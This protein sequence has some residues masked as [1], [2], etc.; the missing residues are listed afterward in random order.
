[1]RMLCR[2]QHIVLQCVRFGGA[3]R[4]TMSTKKVAAI[5]LPVPLDQK[6]ES[7]MR[8]L[9]W[10]AQDD[11]VHLCVQ[12]AALEVW[13]ANLLGQLNGIRAELAQVNQ[14]IN[15][16]V[17]PGVSSVSG[18]RLC[19]LLLFVHHCLSL[20]GSLWSR[21][22]WKVSP[23]RSFQTLPRRRRS[24]PR[25]WCVCTT[26][27]V[28]RYDAHATS[29]VAQKKISGVLSL[30]MGRDHRYPHRYRPM[31]LLLHRLMRQSLI[32]QRWCSSRPHQA[33][34]HHQQRRARL[35]ARLC[36]AG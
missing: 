3:F 21:P 15:G 6:D 35:V 30:S 2:V 14:A 22:Y 13:E 7:V 4:T 12:K 25:R 29:H 31:E 5:L 17:A 10:C 19:G 11:L 27:R 24:R 20:L 9:F 26:A 8:G 18:W 36:G 34:L 1:M 28:A 16:V 23:Q 33:A 32:H